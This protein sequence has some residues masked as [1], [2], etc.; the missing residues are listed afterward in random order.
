[1][2]TAEG[3]GGGQGLTV[4]FCCTLDAQKEEMPSAV[5]REL[6]NPVRVLNRC[7]VMKS[8]LNKYIYTCLREPEISAQRSRRTSR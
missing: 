3:A 8:L 6:V 2:N 1:M 4:E 7:K 5:V